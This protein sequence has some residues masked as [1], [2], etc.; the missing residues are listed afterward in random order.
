MAMLPR[1]TRSLSLSGLDAGPGHPWSEGPRA[2]IMW[3]ASLGYG[4]V[5]LDGAAAG[6]R[7]RELTRSA[8]R[9][10]A[11]LLR[12]SQL[13]FSGLDL[14]IP[15][16]HFLDA[17]RMDYA[18]SVVAQSLELA[19]DLSRDADGRAVVSLA[20]PPEAAATL[21]DSLSKSAD[22]CGAVIAD[23][24]WQV[25]AA[26]GGEGS[27]IRVGIDPAAVLMAGGDPAAEVSRL[28]AAPASA[29][30]SDV[31]LG[32]RVAP[33]ARGGRLDVLA[34]EVALVTAKY[35]SPLV[36]D[37]RGVSEQAKAAATQLS[38]AE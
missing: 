33:G 4:A 5:Q 8:R 6:V 19:A 27:L 9:D 32:G 15:P 34:Y 28:G 26:A 2:A 23:H 12:R 38:G 36:V 29:R 20:F 10:L 21:I 3:A 1:L 30:L 14:W 7:A 37:L 11:A 16:A 31:T 17:A 18:A 22:R 13:A 35:N 25:K 24:A